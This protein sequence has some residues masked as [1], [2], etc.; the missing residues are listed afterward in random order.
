M[1]DERRPRRGIASVAVV[2]GVLVLVAVVDAWVASANV[3]G[4]EALSANALRSVELA[5]DMRWQLSRLVPPRGT[6]TADEPTERQALEWLGRDVRAYEPLATFEGERPEWLT[7]SALSDDLSVDLRRGDSLA[8]RRDANNAIESV[9]RLIGLN[10]IEAEAIGGRLHELGRRQ[11][12]VDLL[13]G[14]TVLLVVIQVAAARLRA[15]ARERMAAAESLELVESKNRALEAFAARAAHVLRSPL[16]PILS[17]ASLIVR[18]GRDEADVRLATRI[19]GSASRMAAVI[20]AMLAFSR[21]GLLPR[22]RTEVRGAV[23][24]ALDELGAATGGADLALEIEEATVACAPEVLGQI[25][26]NVI[27][28]ALKYRAPERPCRLELSTRLETSWVSLEVVDNGQGMD[29]G[30]VRRAFEPFFRGTAE[31][32]GHGLGLAIVDSYVRAMGGSVQLRSEPGVGT[33]VSNRLHRTAT[34]TEDIR[35][36]PPAV[37]RERWTAGT[38]T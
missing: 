30:A 12:L 3:R 32:A 18:A 25:L 16:V 4:T 23:T 20:D 33:R 31:G 24:E 2:A 13:A 28:N 9:N 17:L 1:S 7:L 22:G 37:V 29:P 21:S 14:G 34:G 10:R 38:G 36:P 27:G 5:D 6:G 19:V 15:M 26:R 35:D 8:L 11:I